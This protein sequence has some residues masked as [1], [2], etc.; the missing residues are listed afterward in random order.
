MSKVK[1]EV[2]G[3]CLDLLAVEGLFASDLA[4]RGDPHEAEAKVI[5]PA[6]DGGVVCDFISALKARSNLA[7][8]RRDLASAGGVRKKRADNDFLQHHAHVH[9]GQK[10]Q[11]VRVGAPF[12]MVE[13]R[14]EKAESQLRR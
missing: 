7:A 11:G 6:L 9:S 14:E 2:F 10:D 3:E 8:N 13:L 4:S 5:T 12:G 1:V